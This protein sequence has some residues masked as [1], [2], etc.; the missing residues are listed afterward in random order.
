MDKIMCAVLKE[1]HERQ[2][3]ETIDAPGAGRRALLRDPPG[4]VGGGERR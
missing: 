4:R 2:V 1:A 3:E